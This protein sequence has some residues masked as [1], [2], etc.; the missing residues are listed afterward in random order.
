MP[1][2]LKY[3]RLMMWVLS[4]TVVFSAGD[5]ERL[6]K[7]ALYPGYPEVPVKL[8]FVPLSPGERISEV[9]ITA[10]ERRP[11]DYAPTFTQV[12]DSAG[13]PL[14]RRLE[15]TPEGKF[16]EREVLVGNQGFLRGRK[17]AVLA[18]SAITLEGGRV[19]LNERVEFEVLK[20]PDDADYEVPRVSDLPVWE[21]VFSSMGLSNPSVYGNFVPQSRVDFVI[22]TTEELKPYW[23]PLADLRNAMGLATEIFTVE[24]INSNFP[25]GSPQERIRNFLKYAYKTWG[26]SYLLLGGDHLSVP[27][28]R[29]YV[30]NFSDTLDN[31]YG[32]YF[33]NYLLTDYYYSALDGEW[34][35]SGD[36]WEGDM[37]G[38]WDTGIDLM[39][40]IIVGRVPVRTPE[41]VQRYVASVYAYETTS[42]FDVPKYM[43][44]ASNLFGDTVDPDSADGC[45]ITYDL[46]SKISVGERRYVCERPAVEVVDSVNSF[47]PTFLFGIGHSNHRILMTRN[48]N[49]AYDALSYLY[50]G[51]FSSPNRFVAGWIGCFINDPFSNSIGLEVVKRGKAVA[52]FGSSKADYSISA[53]VFW[54]PF[55]EN[56]RSLGGSPPIGDLVYLVRLNVEWMAGVSV[57]YRSLMFS[58]NLIGDPTVRV[59]TYR[60]KPI[61]VSLNG[62]DSTLTFYVRDSLLNTPLPMSVVSATD[63]RVTFG[64]V[65]TG[66]SGMATLHVKGGRVVWGVWHPTSLVKVGTTHV[67]VEAPQLVVDS[68]SLLSPED[69]TVLRVWVRN[70]GGTPVPPFAPNISSP[71]LY[72]LSG[73]SPAGVPAGG[74]TFYDWRVARSPFVD[75]PRFTRVRIYGDH[76]NDSFY[77]SLA[78]PLVEFVS[79]RWFMNYDTVVL[80]FDIGNSGT[81]T[82]RDIRV[83]VVSGGLSS[84]GPATYD[85]L[86]PGQSTDYSMVM[87]LVGPLTNRHRLR[88]R[89]YAEGVMY[90]TF[91][92]V[93]ANPMPLPIL[94]KHWSEPEQGYVVLRWDYHFPDTLSLGWKVRAGGKTVSLGMLRGSNYTHEIAWG[95]M[96]TLV[97]YP[98]VGG[99][100]GPPLFAEVVSSQPRRVRALNLELIRFS[101]H[102]VYTVNSQPVMAQLLPNTAEPEVVVATAYNR[103]MAFTYDGGEKLWDVNT[104][105]WIYTLPL[106]ADLDDDGT[107]EVVA[108][109]SFRIQV[110]NGRDGSLEWEVD[111]PVFPG[112][113]D[114][115]PLPAYAMITKPFSDSGPFIFIMT[116]KGSR[117]LFNGRG[118]LTAYTLVNTPED[119]LSPP[120]T[121]D[122]NGDG[123]WEI[124]FRLHDSLWVVDGNL[125]PL[126]GFPVYVPD[127]TGGFGGLFVYDVDGDSGEEIFVCGDVNYIVE[128]YGMI[129]WSDSK[130]LDKVNMC[131]PL[132]FNGNGT[133]DV[134]FYHTVRSKVHVW[135][136]QDTGMVQLLFHAFRLG[137]KAKFGIAA[138]ITG[139]GKAEFLLSDSRSKL[140]AFSFGWDVPDHPGFPIDLSDRNGFR[141][142]EVISPAAYEYNGKLYI[143]GPSEAN[144]LHIWEAD[145]RAVWGHRFYNRWSTNS[146]V[147]SLPDE[148]A[149]SVAEKTTKYGRLTYTLKGRE[150]RV[151]GYGEVSVE[152]YSVSGRLLLSADGDSDL[153][154]NLG[155][156]PR[157]VYLLKAEDERERRVYKV[158]LR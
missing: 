72:V 83:V 63:G 43:F 21:H 3:T 138:D 122:F 130:F 45:L 24:W 82:A 153:L 23:E 9:R 34:N 154:L 41:D 55:F 48:S 70:R 114:S 6:P 16:P 67:S 134:A 32:K 156:F 64:P 68:A 60:R 80:E 120:A 143:Y 86:P 65:Y 26:I 49:S 144:V 46:G 127:I 146:P 51:S 108:I 61:K 5:V 2:A 97:V 28:L 91:S 119:V 125:N 132:D 84:L 11:I 10:V 79:A 47:K 33:Q 112:E 40:D 14:R 22:I 77:V 39:P 73:P 95:D 4:Y 19:F 136:V 151:E 133:V 81:D 35:T 139:D 18:V 8:L 29:T 50:V 117:L 62:S 36:A 1:S 44:V 87:K 123:N 90:D 105:G 71:D 102:P 76:I 158:L 152:I 100:E 54:T 25:G 104:Y 124:V 103:I 17:I 106:I 150:L 69:T 58:Y 135:E 98:V 99:V 94:L 27:T 37:E 145:G 88:F 118:N 74:T 89:L 93:I 7:L 148:I 101:A 113:E 157:G 111:L 59:F 52:S 109:T 30:E 66:T 141:S 42:D 131:F 38:R 107:Y 12:I 78:A 56:L 115:L 96:D 15:I 20:G 57:L 92:V 85:L 126:P 137:T 128:P 140:H 129:S 31:F 110:L 75:A 121:Y 155:G 53:E 13:D 147:D 142:A 116:R 149:V